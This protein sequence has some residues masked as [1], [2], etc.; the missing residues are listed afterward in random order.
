M[1][2]NGIMKYLQIITCFVVICYVKQRRRASAGMHLFRRPLLHK[3]S[4]INARQHSVYDFRHS[5]CLFTTVG[6]TQCGHVQVIKGKGGVMVI[7]SVLF[8]FCFFSF[9]TIAH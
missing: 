4:R 7:S 6:A 5:V 3:F 8:C 2:R 9:P 1:R